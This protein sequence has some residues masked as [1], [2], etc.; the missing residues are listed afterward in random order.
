MS[1]M[2]DDKADEIRTENEMGMGL[3]WRDCT[4]NVDRESVGI[5][6]LR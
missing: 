4:Q 5:R 2:L 6:P 3:G 1:L